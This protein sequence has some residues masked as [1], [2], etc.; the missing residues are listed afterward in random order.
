MAL[1]LRSELNLRFKLALTH[2]TGI[3]DPKSLVQPTTR[4]SFGDYQLN[5]VMSAAK[6]LGMNPR[7]LAH[8]V[9]QEVD[10]GGVISS[11]DIAGP[12]F[13]N[14]KIDNNY[15]AEQ[16]DHALTSET[17][18]ADLLPP[19]RIL[20]DY[21]SVNLAKEMHVG[22]L[23]STI[24]GD[25]LARVHEFLGEEV[26]LQNHVGDWGTQF[27]M[28]VAYLAETQKGGDGQFALQDLE[29]FY[30]RAKIRFEDPSFADV[31]RDYVV[32]LQQGDETVLALWKRFV[33]I[34]MEHCEV[35]YRK[36]GVLLTQ[37][38][39]RGES[40]YNPDLLSVVEDLR[41][42]GISVE[43][44]GAEVVLLNE[45]AGKD[46]SPSVFII[47]KT[48]GGFLYGTTDLAAIR[49]RTRNLGIQKCY[50]VVDSRQELH[51]RQ[52]FIVAHKAGFAT[53]SIEL[54]HIDFGMVLGED[55]KPFKTR[56]GG[57]IKL[58]ELLQ[59]AEDRAFELV[60]Q[61]NP[62]LDEGTRRS[63]AKA[64]GIG[65]L[66]YADL[67][68][69]RVTDYVFDWNTMLAFE[70]NTA[71]YLQYAYVRVASV[72][73]KAGEWDHTQSIVFDDPLDRALA[74]H[75][76]RFADVIHQTA[77]ESSPHLLCIYLYELASTFS[78]FYEGCPILVDD[79]A[80]S[81]RLKLCQLTASILASGL[82]LLGITVLDEM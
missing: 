81:S 69:N 82:R 39:V 11:L 27:G 74:L 13:I 59:E 77:H 64:I 50:Y 70:G 55:G 7:E 28:L 54:K 46:G 12:G 31:A 67:S 32:R 61:K 53:D 26:I 62:R 58:I 30:R 57:S 75:L 38:D 40:F 25:C 16:I 51:F 60:G 21:S 6:T 22:H 44:D 63:V 36:L 35:V 18:G 56:A 20:I 43:S 47:K 9:A 78:R 76:I 1:S 4:A 42:S 48:D 34:S 49:F 45:L 10:H 17:H 73:Q 33:E 80:N 19:N 66:K 37:N 72:L 23:R 24:I 79:V 71:P 5:S 3:S 15:L 68:K 8:R 52:L 2:V 29:S 65:A 14:I 41:K